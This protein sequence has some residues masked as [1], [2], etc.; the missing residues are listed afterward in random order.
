M[1]LVTLPISMALRPFGNKFLQYVY[2]DVEAHGL[3]IADG[4]D[5]MS[6]LSKLE[7]LQARSGD[8]RVHI[9]CSYNNKF[10]AVRREGDSVVAAVAEEPVEDESAWSCTMFLP[11]NIPG[12][13][14]NNIQLLHV[15]LGRNLFID[16]QNPVLAVS[17]EVAANPQHATHMIFG[18]FDLAPLFMMP[19][20]VAFKGDNGDYLRFMSINNQPFLQFSSGVDKWHPSVLHE[21][22]NDVTDYGDFRIRCNASN[23]NDGFWRRNRGSD[24]EWIHADSVLLPHNSPLGHQWGDTHFTAVKVAENNEGIIVAFRSTNNNYLMRRSASN[25]QNVLSAHAASIIPEARLVVEELVRSRLI[26]NVN[27]NLLDSRI[28]AGNPEIATGQDFENKTSLPQTMELTFTY[29]QTRTSTWNATVW[30]TAGVS[31]T[32]R[33]GIPFIAAGEITTSLEVTSTYEWG[34]SYEDI[35]SREDK[36]TVTV[37]PMTHVTVSRIETRGSC[38]VPFSYTQQDTLYNWETS[39]YQKH[40]GLY[41][42]VNSFNIHYQAREESLPSSATQ[43]TKTFPIFPHTSRLLSSVPAG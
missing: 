23:V 7:V 1:A 34:R 17:S 10:L 4:D 19:R 35:E 32:F 29:T 25:V 30:T 33:T 6:P 2:E 20:H 28:Y 39:V 41:R 42:G 14:N 21:V 5:V 27:F 31:T 18:F 43:E 9:R 11:A 38:D 24:A 13:S 36:I 8:G 15:Q 22:S 37:P 3:L 16:R 12:Y 26:Y 40:D